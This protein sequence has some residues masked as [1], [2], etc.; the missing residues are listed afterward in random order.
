MGAEE[1]SK[2]ISVSLL[3]KKQHN[4]HQGNPFN[5]KNPGSDNIR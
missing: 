4:I 2:D 5:P 1:L 3:N